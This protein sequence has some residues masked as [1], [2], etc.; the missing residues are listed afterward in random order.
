L[1]VAIGF[2]LRASDPVLATELTK[3]ELNAIFTRNATTVTLDDKDADKPVIGFDIFPK[4]NNADGA[5]EKLQVCKKARTATISSKSD[6]TDKGLEYLKE[7]TGME[8]L[9]LSGTKYTEKGLANLKTLTKLKKLELAVPDTGEGLAFLKE[10]KELK[11]LRLIGTKITD[12]G[13]ANLKELKSLEELNLSD[14]SLDDMAIGNLAGLTDLK[15]LIISRTKITGGSVAT[16]KELKGLEELYASKPGSK[17]VG[18]KLVTTKEGLDDK[19]AAEIK[20]ALTNLKK[21]ER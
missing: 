2:V 13:F 9:K 8:D 18:K 11:Y 1:A 10:C 15:K 19:A 7:L 17:L 3:E 5:L 21:L 16:I 20:K 14:T 12:E 4:G 6:V